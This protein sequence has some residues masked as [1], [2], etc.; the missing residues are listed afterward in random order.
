MNGKQTAFNQSSSVAGFDFGGKKDYDAEVRRSSQH[1]GGDFLDNFE[2][3]P[4]QGLAKPNDLFGLLSPERAPTQNY[5]AVNPMQSVFGNVFSPT[6]APPA[7]NDSSVAAWMSDQII[8][9]G[10]DSVHLDDSDQ[11][12]EETGALMLQAVSL[13]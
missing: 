2:M 13:A 11:S 10:T 7:K 12:D 9:Q 6:S 1:N 3:K 4:V 5:G 8:I